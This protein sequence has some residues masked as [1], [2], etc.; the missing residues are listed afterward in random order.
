MNVRSYG[1][2]VVYR[3]LS[4]PSLFQTNQREQRKRRRKG[5]RVR[6][7][8][9]LVFHLVFLLFPF[10]C[11]EEG[12][13]THSCY[14]SYRIIASLFHLRAARSFRPRL[15]GAASWSVLGTSPASSRSQ[16]HQLHV[17]ESRCTC[18]YATKS[19]RFYPSL[20]IFLFFL[21]FFFLFRFLSRN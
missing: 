21:L 1:R 14:A 20:S 12:M 11:P 19:P 3:R 6:E 17:T 2:T 9:F 16:S 7:R 4:F 10:Q 8:P 13:Y 15:R 18:V 5:E